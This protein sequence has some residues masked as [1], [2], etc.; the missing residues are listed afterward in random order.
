MAP[1]PSIPGPSDD[2]V[3]AAERAELRRRALTAWLPLLAAVVLNAAMLVW[4]AAALPGLPDTVPT[5]WGPN[6]QP[7]AWEPTTF[8]SVAFSPLMNLGTAAFLALIAAAMPL[9]APAPPGQTPWRRVRQAGVTRGVRQ[10]V[11]WIPLIMSLL[12]LP[13]VVSVLRGGDGGT[14]WWMGP[15][16]VTLLIPGIL[17]ALA[18]SVR[19][20]SRWADRAAE[21]LGYRPS[22]DEAAEEALWTPLGM[23]RDPSDPSTFPPKRE[24]YGVGT[25]VN[26][27]TALGR[28]LV[29]GFLAVFCV[30]LP[31]SIWAAAWATR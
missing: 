1:A 3:P 9:L 27:A 31:L 19:R 8:G 29:T 13:A 25:T 6:G 10:G 14:P 5:H 20:G 30:L 21:R 16:I 26:L 15:L 11:G 28:L 22:P 18:W 17:A 7:D 4:V 2:A 12:T 24:G 23:K